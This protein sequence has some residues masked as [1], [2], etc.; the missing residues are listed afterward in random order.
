VPDLRGVAGVTLGG[1]HSCARLT[2]G[3][4]RCWGANYSGQ[5]GDG[6]AD[7]RT[8]PVPVPGLSGVAGL[9]LGDEHSCARLTSGRLRCW[10]ANYSGQL[11]DGT[12]DD[13][14]TPVQVRFR[15]AP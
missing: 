12:T 11:G 5:L 7:N 13:R 10:G 9:A 14:L 4:L 15:R 8:T 2:N 3:R 1:Y 6:T